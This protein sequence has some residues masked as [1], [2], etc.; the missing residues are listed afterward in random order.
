MKTLVISA[1][2]LCLAGNIFA[3]NSVVPDGQNST[4]AATTEP[5][6]TTSYRDFDIDTISAAVHIED[7]IKHRGSAITVAVKSNP[8]ALGKSTLQFMTLIPGVN[9]L[10]IYGNR[11]PAAVYVN[12][13]ELKLSSDELARYLSNL[14]AEDVRQIQILP[15]HGVK[16]SAD[17]KGG[18]IKIQLR[19][20]EDRQ[21]SGTFGLPVRLNDYDAAVTTNPSLNVNYMS[22]KLSSYSYV[23]ANYMQ[24]E[25]IDDTYTIGD[26]D[27]AQTTDEESTD[28][29]YYAFT[30]DQSL[31]WNVADDHELGFA[32]NGFAKPKEWETLASPASL[33]YQNTYLY[34]GGGT[35]T[36]NWNY[37]DNG[38]SIG[39]TGDYLFRQDKYDEDYR[40]T[41]LDRELTNNRTNKNTWSVKADGDH[42]FGDDISDLSYGA[43]YLGMNADQKYSQTYE[44][45]RFR[46]NEKLFGAYAEFYTAFFDESLEFDVG[47]RYEGYRAD[48][49]YRNPLLA[50]RTNGKNSFDSLFPSV[51]LSYMTDNGVSYTSL[52]YSRDIDRPAMFEYD[53]TVYRDGD[54]VFSVG[55]PTLLPQFENSIS[56]TETINNS[57]T[58]MLSYSW[59]KDIYDVV[60]H[61]DGDYIYQSEDNIGSSRKLELYADTRFWIVKNRLRAQF[62]AD[63]DYT[64]Y[65]NSEYGNL[66]TWNA[67]LMGTLALTL[68]KSWG[69]RRMGHLYDPHHSPNA[70]DIG[71]LEPQCLHNKGIRQQVHL[72][73]HRQQS[74][75]QP[76]LQGRIED[77]RRQLQQ[78]QQILLPDFRA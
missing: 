60:Y 18:V 26:E 68:P 75:V 15:T 51:S 63:V 39:F 50:D 31:I 49:T 66:S 35:I 74:R 16:Y 36:Y 32:V 67:Y 57:H 1:I 72:D 23:S 25:H 65:V 6:D 29:G 69:H 44:S 12:G 78:P 21:Y 27:G 14:K 33:M 41:G 8:E 20:N 34:T 76:Q 3:Q 5:Q 48:W 70:V 59:V 61:Q 19:S 4:S 73:P 43:F 40:P 24:N 45:D 56:L 7:Y 10:S 28:R 55:A 22:R 38:S 64:K 42:F 54:N 37:D 2:C 13:R 77:L 30:L 46:F 58:F 71:Q 11:T 17:T 9:G 52:E 53:P 47:L 62:T